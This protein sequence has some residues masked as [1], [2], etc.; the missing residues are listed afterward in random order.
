M[1]DPDAALLMVRLSQRGWATSGD[2]QAALGKSQPTM[3]RLLAAAAPQLLVLGAGRRTRYALP[4]AI[5]GRAPQQPLHWVH[6]D[7]R[8]ERWGTLSFVVGQ[9][10]HIAGPGFELDG[11]GT[12]PWLLAPLRGEGFLGRLLAQRL[13]AQGLDRDPSRWTLEQQL[14]AAL[15]SGDGPGAL[16]LGEPLGAPSAPIDNYD[17]AADDVAATLPAGSSAGGEQAKFLARRVE[18]GA[19]VLVKFTPPRGTPFGERWHDLLHA[20]CIALDTLAEHGV[21]V[22]PSRVVETARRT[23][24]ESTRFDRV[25]PTGRRHALPLWAAHDA[26]VSG[27]RRHWAATCEALVAQKRL[28]PEVAAQAHALLHFGRLIGN[29]DM[30]FGN[31]SLYV[32]PTDAARGRF[33]LAPLYDMLP[34]RWRPDPSTGTLDLDP[35]TPEPIDLQSAARPI[36]AACWRR[37]AEHAP[38]SKPFRALAIEMARRVG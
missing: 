25:G 33:T 21:P 38:V 22:A 29:S 36:A 9:R 20:E 16:V 32:A 14:L 5:G 2:L 18:D 7:G 8:I 10:V 12:L 6:E 37:L 15:H 4:Q 1:E 34:M 35:F 13:A 23:C 28:L 11:V 24:L 31:L 19:A 26:F 17:A 30:H 27:P 3:S